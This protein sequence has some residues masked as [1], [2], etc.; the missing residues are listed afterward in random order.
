MEDAETKERYY[1]EI[2]APK[3]RELAK[4][5]HSHGLSFLAV[6]EWEPGEHGRTAYFQESQGLPL[7]MA[8]WAAKCGGNVDLF[9]LAV[10]WHAKEHGHSSVFLSQQGIPTKPNHGD[11]GTDSMRRG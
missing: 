7:L 8:N 4:A 2:L 10:Q 5:A 1:D 9:W 6:T 3:L 11:T